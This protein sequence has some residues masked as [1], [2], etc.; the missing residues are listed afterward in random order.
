MGFRKI[1][2][3]SLQRGYLMLCLDVQFWRLER[4]SVLLIV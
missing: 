4:L 3:I 1:K 2:S